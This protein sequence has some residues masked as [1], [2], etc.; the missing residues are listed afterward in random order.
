MERIF[1]NWKTSSGG[2]MMI[3]SSVGE[4]LQL[5]GG[6]APMMKIITSPSFA[7]FVGGVSMFFAKDSDVTGGDRDNV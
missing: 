4:L 1:K 3:M 7:A 6:G 5:V 2:M